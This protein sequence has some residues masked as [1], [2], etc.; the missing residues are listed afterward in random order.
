MGREQELSQLKE[1]IN[2]RLAQGRDLQEIEELMLFLT[3]SSLYQDMKQQ[4]YRYSGSG[5]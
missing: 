3:E 5:G 1:K 4:L 2:L